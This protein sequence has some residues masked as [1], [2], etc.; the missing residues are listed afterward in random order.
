MAE[1]TYPVSEETSTVI[2]VMF[3]NG[4]GFVGVLVFGALLQAG[5][6]VPVCVTIGVLYLIATVL[7]LCTKTEL[8]RLQAEK[9]S[10]DCP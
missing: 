2:L 9:S 7:A 10:F 6:E 8:K 5:Y 4:F 1:I 3:M